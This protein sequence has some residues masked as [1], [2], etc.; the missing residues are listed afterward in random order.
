VHFDDPNLLRAKTE[1]IIHNVEVTVLGEIA[2]F[3]QV[4]SG[5]LT[6]SGPIRRMDWKD[7]NNRYM[8]I[9]N[10]AQPYFADYIVPDDGS[11][12]I[13]C[14]RRENPNLGHTSQ[15]TI[16]RNGEANVAVFPPVRSRPFPSPARPTSIL[17]PDPKRETQQEEPGPYF[18]FLEGHRDD[19]P[20]GLVLVRKDDGTFKRIGYFRMGRSE[21][22]AGEK[23]DGLWS[24]G[25]RDWEWDEGFEECTITIV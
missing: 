12:N 7:V 13:C 20:T 18:W 11:S 2:P 19:G 4:T 23:M 9:I 21:L 17:K 24:P 6:L 8:V 22:T 5:S 25:R 1:V 16:Y 14:N 15:S 10:Q 3:G